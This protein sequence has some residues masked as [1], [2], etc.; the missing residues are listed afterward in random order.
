MLTDIA[1]GCIEMFLWQKY[2]Q[3]TAYGEKYI[4]FVEWRLF[5]TQNTNEVFWNGMNNFQKY[6]KNSISS[7]GI[8]N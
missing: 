8:K 1:T 7:E 6:L 4:L 3:G 2:K 5:I